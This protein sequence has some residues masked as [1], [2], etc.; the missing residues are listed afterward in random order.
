[1][2]GR[3]DRYY[4]KK[5]ED[6]TNLRC[7]FLVDLSKSMS[8]ASETMGGKTKADYAITVAASLSYFLSKQGDATGLLS[9][10]AG[11]RD[12]MPARNR[13]GHL[14]QM[15]LTLDKPVS[16]KE[17]NLAM[18]LKRIAELVNKRG[19][20]VLIS[21]LLSPYET[22]ADALTQLC[23]FGHE[24]IVFQVLD[25]A[26]IEFDYSDS[27]QF[28]DLESGTMLYIDPEKV[29]S[30]YRA[31]FLAHQARIRELCVSNGITHQVLRTDEPLELALFHFLTQR[32]S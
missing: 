19:I 23:A 9:F 32:S 13:P 18:P 7:Y 27:S 16:G 4:L 20:M 6:E 17:T 14:H 15:M 30:E 26:E 2:F 8:F 24:V 28:E 12:Y 21:D 25:P 1:L 29:R 5:F 10:D 11:I 3:S 22:F 31:N